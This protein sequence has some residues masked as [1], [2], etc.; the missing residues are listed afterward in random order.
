MELSTKTTQELKDIAQNFG[1][2]TTGNKDAL[3]ARIKEKQ[4]GSIKKFSFD[5]PAPGKVMMDSGL[6]TPSKACTMYGLQDGDVIEASVIDCKAHGN[7]NDVNQFLIEFKTDKFSFK[8]WVQEG[9]PL[10]FLAFKSRNLTFLVKHFKVGSFDGLSLK[11][12][13]TKEDEDLIKAHNNTVE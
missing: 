3:I 10:H 5:I 1:L 6:P 4:G 8:K 7:F 13:L 11:L 2:P 9:S 12:S